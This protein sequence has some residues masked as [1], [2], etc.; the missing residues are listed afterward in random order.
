[1]RDNVR[2]IEY[3]ATDKHGKDITGMVR[4]DSKVVEELRVAV[5]KAL[6]EAGFE[7]ESVEIHGLVPYGET[8]IIQ[9]DGADN[10]I[11]HT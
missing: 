6:M 4:S 2:K 8:R 5:R 9:M 1:M 11:T 3:S 7:V 10:P